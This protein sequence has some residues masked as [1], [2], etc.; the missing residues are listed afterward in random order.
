MPRRSTFPRPAALLLLASAL[1]LS[2]CSSPARRT[3]H[4]NNADATLDMLAQA[5]RVCAVTLAIVKDRK[6]ATIDG[7]NGCARSGARPGADK[8]FQAASLSKPVFAY[9]VLKLAAQGKLALDAPVMRYLPQGYRHGFSPLQP[10]P[11]ELVGDPL[12]RAVTIRMLLNH[13]AG[14]PNWSSGPLGF[15]TAPGTTW[16]YSGEGYVLLQRAVETVSGQPLDQFMRSQVFEPLGMRHSSYVLNADVA[17]ALLPGTKANGAPRTT[18]ELRHPNAAI[19]LYTSTADYAAFLVAVL[20]D[21]PLLRQLGEAPVLVDPSLDLAWGLGWGLARE[22]DDAL[23]WQWGNNPGYRAFVMASPRTG[24]G[25]VMLSNSENGLKL[26]EPLARNILPGEH[27]VFR[28]AMLEDDVLNLLCNSL[29]I[30]L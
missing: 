30:C 18:M 7:A 22:G 14:L 23:F 20:N 13:S 5:H 21:A 4:A 10:E 16:S 3:P 12:L 29:R 25:F 6:L 28:F 2:A 27:K 19:T 26:A 1:L 24:D 11:S 15:K 9:A 8:V 17:A